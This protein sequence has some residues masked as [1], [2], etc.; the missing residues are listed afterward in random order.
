LT[1]HQREERIGADLGG[2]HHIRVRV[3]E[4]GDPSVQR[5][6][7]HV[8]GVQQRHRQ[9]HDAPDQGEH[10]RHPQ[11]EFSAPRHPRHEAEPHD[12]ERDREDARHH[13]RRVVRSDAPSERGAHQG[14]ERTG[15]G[16]AGGQW[17]LE[18]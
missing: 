16:I 13:R 8:A 2:R 18:R 5:V 14:G 9:D 4:R 11:R 17:R 12:D 6:A 15:P 7:V 3:V 10:E 1:A